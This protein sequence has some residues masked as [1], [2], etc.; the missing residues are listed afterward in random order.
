[1]SE[2]PRAKYVELAGK[3]RYFVSD[4]RHSLMYVV[5]PPFG[6]SIYTF[7]DHKWTSLD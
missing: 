7:E 1:M 6:R 4:S 2:I 3:F 5:V